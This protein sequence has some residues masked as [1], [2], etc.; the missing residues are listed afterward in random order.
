[1]RWLG[2]KLNMTL[3]DALRLPLLLAPLLMLGLTGTWWGLS[4]LKP[5]L[6][7]TPWMLGVAAMVQFG[8]GLP[9]Y[10]RAL[11]KLIRLHI[12]GDTLLVTGATA[13]F[14]LSL[15]RYLHMM[16]AAEI[17][18]QVIVWRDAAFGASLVSVAVLGDMILRRAQ[19]TALLPLPPAP[20]GRVVVAP[21]DLVPADGVVVDGLSEIQ[22]PVGADD[23]FPIVVG[24]GAHVH[25]GARNGDGALTIEVEKRLAGPV[26]EV[27]TDDRLQNLLDW[28]ARATL[29]VVV[30]VIAAQLWQGSGSGDPVAASLRMLSLAAPLG[31]GFVVTAP[32]SEALAMARRLGV[33]IRDISMFDRLRRIGGVVIGH[34][35]VL[36]PDRLRLITAT[37]IDGIAATDL[38]RRAAAVAEAGYDPWGK[39]ILDFAVGYRM[40]LKP[41]THYRCKIGEGMS[42]RTENQEILIGTR[43]FLEQHGI[44][45]K[46]L[47][48]A[49]A[50]AK[51]QGRRLRWV[52]ETLP[53][54]RVQGLLI[55]G[56]PSVNGAVET[57]KNLGRM[58]LETGWLANSDDTAHV[59]LSKH[60]KIDRLLPDRADAAEHGLMQMRD[61]AGPLLVVA[62]DEPPAGLAPDDALLPFGRRLME[63]MP[64]SRIGSIRHDPRII[65]D[66]LMLAARHRQMVVMNAVIAY[67]AALLFAF[68][69]FW[70][71]R[72]TDLGSYEVGIVLLLALSS[73]G[74]RAMSTTANEVDEE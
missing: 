16:P 34:R 52:G 29:C 3:V 9:V 67:L 12:D 47:A 74:L 41:A 28:I 2:A 65:V 56:A 55:F 68:A 70:L 63:Q 42:A 73:L 53:T 19:Y 46:A 66:L 58:G 21:G 48:P 49:A 36:V 71:G 32:S 25:L 18:G 15:W 11:G 50:K 51:E 64:A 8:I 40:R 6:D 45:C 33:E 61:E 5:I 31:L 27:V 57:V 14:A 30:G 43:E 20:T 37:P 60:L 13:A 62:A 17:D 26:R 54:R 23:V 1:M 7:Q 4:P 38:I 35:G 69:P 24:A 59:A 10:L 72:R 22:D 39:A 44:D